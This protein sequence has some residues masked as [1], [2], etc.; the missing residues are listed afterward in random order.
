MPVFTAIGTGLI[1]A[2]I[3][4]ASAFAT[5]ITAAGIVGG[6]VGTMKYQANKASKD[7]KSAAND[8]DVRAKQA[9]TDMQN[10]QTAA[11]NQAQESIN[12]RARARVSGSQ[13]IY[14]SPLGIGGTAD[15]NRKTL[16]GQ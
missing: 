3:G 11:A 4:G 9:V 12:S 6:T 5:G 16:L 10:A 7:A 8:A 1:A 13:S 2:G 14:T 15:V